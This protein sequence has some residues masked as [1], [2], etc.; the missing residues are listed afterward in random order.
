LYSAGESKGANVGG[1]VGGVIAA[2]VAIAVIII[3]VVIMRRRMDKKSNMYRHNP[4]EQMT[5]RSSLTNRK[6]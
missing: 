1:I 4:G 5:H 3:I 2:I 6:T